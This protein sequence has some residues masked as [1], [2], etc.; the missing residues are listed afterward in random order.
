MVRNPAGIIV[1]LVLPFLQLT[2]FYYCIGGYPIGL[3]LAVI[4][5]EMMNYQDCF[6]SSLKFT[7]IHDYECDFNK[8][9]CRF[10]SHLNDSVA[11]KVYYDNYDDAY[12]D[13]KHGR[14]IGIIYFAPNYTE[15]FSR[16]RARESELDDGTFDSS[17]IQINLD[18]S[19]QQITYFLELKIY[20]TFKEYSEHLMADCNLPIKIGNVPISL[21]NPI[22]GSFDEDF[23]YSMAPGMIMIMLFFVAAVLTSTVFIRDRSEGIWNRTLI[24]GVSATELFSANVLSQLVII[25]L[26]CFEYLITAEILFDTSSRGDNFSV[27]V[28][29]FMLGLTGMFVG[30]LIS[31]Y[32]DKFYMA[33]IILTGISSPMIALAGIIWPL[34]GM[35]MVLRYLSVV[36]P[37][38]KPSF[39]MRDVISKGYTWMDP[40]VFSGLSVSIFYSALSI[41]L[42]IVGL[43]YRKYSRTS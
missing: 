14:V 31:I 4:N 20:Q 18:R 43:N 27:F 6:N 16:V 41:V 19:N 1:L 40:S 26:Q 25:V 17:R 13:A 36:L 3:K 32:C 37:F 39:A 28:L 2:L 23:K 21:E 12:N 15:S 24:A 29:I 22:Y 9:S 8:I 7:N 10:L 5:D 33:N 42:C 11:T 35:P 38:T 30:F 34:E